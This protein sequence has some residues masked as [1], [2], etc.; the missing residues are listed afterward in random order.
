MEENEA[1]SAPAAAPP[2]R[3]RSID[4]AADRGSSV[5]PSWR[6][7]LWQW[8]ASGRGIA[9]AVLL[10]A[11]GALAWGMYDAR[12]VVHTVTVAGNRLVDSA[13]LAEL[14]AV[15]GEPIWTIE[16]SEV[17]ARL[18]AHPYVAGARVTLHL[19]DEVQIEVREPRH[20]I[21]WEAGAQRYAIA[22]DGRLSPLAAS[23]PISETAIIHDWRTTPLAADAR[24]SPTVVAL[25]QMLLVRLPAE[26]GLAIQS[27]GWDP[28]H[29]LVVQTSDGSALLWGE[30][31][32]LD[33]QLQI[34]EALKRQQIAYRVLD[35][36]GRIAAYR[37]ES[38]STLPLPASTSTVST[39]LQSR[40]P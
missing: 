20:A 19:P 17:E 15:R 32:T 10:A 36:R 39:T 7:R 28:A 3:G 22:A 4:R 9:A 6:R 5:R 35:L 24:V 34:V 12:F 23:V 8:M 30:S 33:R 37:T 14:A 40:E 2:L 27:L 26:T 38:D 21:T 31:E 25:A 1:P 11:T 18:H 16:P 13:T 29:G